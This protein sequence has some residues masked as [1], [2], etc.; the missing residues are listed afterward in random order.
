MTLK[1]FILSTIFLLKH[2]YTMARNTIVVDVIRVG[3]RIISNRFLPFVG[4]GIKINV[5]KISIT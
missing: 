4:S 1:L 5:L 3:I 2:T